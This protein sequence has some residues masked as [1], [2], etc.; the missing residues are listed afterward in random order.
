[1][2]GNICI[3]DSQNLPPSSPKKLVCIWMHESVHSMAAC[4]INFS[5]EFVIWLSVLG[6][7]ISWDQFMEEEEMGGWF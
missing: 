5:F 4:D 2:G 6:E 3:Q 7:C 1:M